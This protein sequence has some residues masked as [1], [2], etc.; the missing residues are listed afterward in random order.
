MPIVYGRKGKS[1]VDV[2][3]WLEAGMLS[4]EQLPGLALMAPVC[5]FTEEWYV[6][7]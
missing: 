2:S 7:I 3:R 1:R 4:R 6:G 5:R